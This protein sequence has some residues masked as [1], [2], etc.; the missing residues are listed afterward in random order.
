M[1][2]WATEDNLGQISHKE[3]KNKEQIHPY[4]NKTHQ[5]HARRQMK[6]ITI[7]Q[8]E[9]KYIKKMTEKYE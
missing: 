4:D 5:R 6:T 9:L 2:K 7:V 8:H 3:K 1:Y